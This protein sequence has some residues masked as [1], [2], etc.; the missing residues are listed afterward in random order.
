MASLMLMVMKKFCFTRA[1]SPA[2]FA[3]VALFLLNASFTV[4]SLCAAD[5][6]TPPMST[7]TPSPSPVTEI[8]RTAPDYA[9]SVPGANS[10]TPRIAIPA[11]QNKRFA[12]LSWPKFIRLANGDL[13]AAYIAGTFHGTHGGGCPSVSY[14]TDN[15]KTWTEPQILKEFAP[16]KPYTQ[17]GN[18]A[19]GAAS[20]GTLIIL[21]M[22]YNADK[23][24]AIF[25]WR[26]KDNGR[27]W[28]EDVDVTALGPDKTG[29]VFGRILEVPGTADGGAS[30]LMVLGHYRKGAAP[31]DKGIWLS[32][33]QDVGKTWSAPR[34]ISEVY[35]VEPVLVRT[36]AGRLIAFLRGENTPSRGRQ[37][38]A[39]SDDAGKTW[40]TELSELDAKDPSR[41]RI[42]APFAVE[43]P[44]KPG[45]LLVLTTERSLKGETPGCIWLWR[46][47]ATASTPKFQRE[48]VLLNIPRVE[49]DKHTDFGYPWLLPL[50]PSD[51]TD[52]RLLMLYYHGEMHGPSAIWSVEFT[53]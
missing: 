8:E 7:N 48:R 27:T 28:Q 37:S 17:S 23:A 6:S 40:R 11:P 41:A 44:Q 25:G 46:G 26:S 38:L 19:L 52:K 39:I 12:H 34:R 42:V 16:G 50:N 43:D 21:A 45:S 51:A 35:A 32:T 36:S 18:L 47:D 5:I 4:S 22:A 3:V 13:V 30:A 49:G 9:A 1:I 29:S 2:L 53:P 15:G 20:D 31:Y 14:S 10:G 24:N 33:S